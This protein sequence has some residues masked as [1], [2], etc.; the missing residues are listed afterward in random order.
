MARIIKGNGDGPGGRNETYSIPGRGVVGR[1]SLVREVEQGK[2][3]DFSIYTREGE[4]Y[5][6]GN[7]DSMAGNN[8]DQ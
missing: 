8:V 2:H 4:K 7:P 3:P 5:V 1:K 6:R